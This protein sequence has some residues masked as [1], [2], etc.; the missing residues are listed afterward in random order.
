MRHIL[1]FL[2]A[3]T[4]SPWAHATQNI[5][6]TDA[7]VRLPPPGAKVGAAYLTLQSKQ[8]ISLTGAKSPAAKTVELHSMRMDQGVMLM[9]HLPS[10]QIEAGQPLKLEPGGL[11]LM[12]IDLK[13]PLKAGDTVQ[14]DLNFS[15]GLAEGKGK[16]KSLRVQA[17][18]RAQD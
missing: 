11:H 5:S 3:L 8:R 7:W 13:K 1:P 10:L 16:T 14:F 12:L 17:V 4:L 9:R 6:A 2:L 18:V 15:Q